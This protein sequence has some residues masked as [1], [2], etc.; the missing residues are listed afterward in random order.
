MPKDLITKEDVSQA[1]IHRITS[2]VYSTGDRIPSVR[3][4]AQEI[5]SNRNTVNKAY[6]MLLE[7]G[8]IES[9]SS[10]RRGFSVK[11]V[12]QLGIRSKGELL[13]YFYK[14]S[15][16]LVWQSMAAGVSDDEMLDQIKVAFN[17][18]YGQGKIRLVFFE[19][20]E[21][22]VIEMGQG[23]IDA[24]GMPI[25]CLVLGNI[26]SDI[27]DIAKNYDLLITTFHHLSEIT[28]AL[29]HQ[30]ESSEKVVGIETRPTSEAML[31]VARLPNPNIGLVCSVDASAH[32]LKHIFYGYLPDW[33]I[34]A[35]T[36]D[37]PE[38]VTEIVHKCDHLILTHTCATEVLELTGRSPDVVINF[39]IAE[40]SI[41]YLSQR[42]HQIQLDKT[43]HLQVLIAEN[44]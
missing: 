35:T 42:I 6:Q 25:K 43:K 33:N 34:E 16:N 39:H 17:K 15:V 26:D 40:Q 12:D 32:M 31:R 7:L 37:Y 23:L 9:T 28:E 29:E 1:I 14:R 2:G 11:N 3:Q 24:L 20:N 30:C 41:S 18:V 8:I 10:G 38:V 4:L 36:C 22:D 27:T 21:H 13:D 19:C 44:N 5:G